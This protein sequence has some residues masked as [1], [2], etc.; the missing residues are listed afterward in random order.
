MGLFTLNTRKFNNYQ[1][2]HK[3]TLFI[4]GFVIAAFFVGFLSTL[5]GLISVNSRKAGVSNFFA[6]PSDDWNQMIREGTF[7][8]KQD[9]MN[10]RTPSWCLIPKITFSF[11]FQFYLL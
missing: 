9:F 7:L 10:F 6:G 4:L 2:Y 3:L 5:F 8:T 1:N 11:G